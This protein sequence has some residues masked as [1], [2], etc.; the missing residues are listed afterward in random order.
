M[1]TWIFTVVGTYW[2]LDLLSRVI[3]MGASHSDI[4]MYLLIR[5]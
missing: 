1:G 5:G 4:A 3:D 2:P